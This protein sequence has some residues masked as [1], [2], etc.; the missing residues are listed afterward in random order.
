MTTT[1]HGARSGA[2]NCRQCRRSA[3]SRRSRPGSRTWVNAAL[4]SVP[5]AAAGQAS[6][7]QPG[8]AGE[9]REHSG[10]VA[11]TTKS[12]RGPRRRGPSSTRGSRGRRR[13]AAAASSSAS[14]TTTGRL[15]AS[16]SRAGPPASRPGA[17]QMCGRLYCENVSN[18]SR[19]RDRRRRDR[20]QQ[21]ARAPGPPRPAAARSSA[22]EPPRHQRQRRRSRGS[23]SRTAPATGR[24]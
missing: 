19:D 8:R 2:T 18:C 12:S 3:P 16:R 9:R 20:R 21:R 17:T 23:P 24:C 15:I 4:R 10:C 14:R 7:R 1:G 22:A 6:T 13:S 11:S 5:P